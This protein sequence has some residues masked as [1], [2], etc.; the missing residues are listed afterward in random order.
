MN[1]MTQRRHAIIY[2][3]LGISLVLISVFAI[4]QYKQSRNLK[5]QL[6]SQYARSFYEM[7]GYVD[8]I[9]TDLRKSML[10]SSPYQLASLAGNIYR[11]SN[12]AKA[13]VF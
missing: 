9:E 10:V 11:M 1:N 13:F 5:L 2:T 6:N 3:I 12:S 4:Y 8:K 7:T